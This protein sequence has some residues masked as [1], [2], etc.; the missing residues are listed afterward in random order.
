MKLRIGKKETKN[1]F[2]NMGNHQIS[3]TAEFVSLIKSRTDEKYNYFVSNKTRKLYKLISNVFSKNVMDKIFQNRIGLSNEFDGFIGKN[4]FEAIVEFGCGYSLRGF[5]YS[6]KNKDRIYIDTDFLEV[7]DAKKQILFNICKDS[8]IVYPNNYVLLSVDILTDDIAKKLNPYLKN[9]NLFLAEGLTPYFNF[10]QYSKFLRQ[11]RP[12]LKQSQNVFF[13]QENFLK[14][15][16]TVYKVLRKFVGFL[17][18]NSSDLKFETKDDLIK[19]LNNEGFD[20]CRAYY[21]DENL[22]YRIN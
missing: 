13:S 8:N 3:I 21:K 5:E 14:K 1:K 20:D 7:V 19:F 6:L 9:K 12:F 11:I 15:H 22:F 17:T 2:S 18:K 4:N 16:S 10:K